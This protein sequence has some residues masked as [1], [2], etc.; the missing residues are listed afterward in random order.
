MRRAAIVVAAGT[1]TRMGADMPKALMPVAG[2]PLL[3]WSVETLS[4]C[5]LI[6]HVVVVAPSGHERPTRMALGVELANLSVTAGGASRARSV[7][8]GLERI[9]T[10]TEQ[11]VI[12]DAAR[13]LVTAEHL[14]SVLA[15][16]VD[17][18]GAII[19]A[20]AAD[21]IKRATADLTIAETLDRSELWLAQTPQAFVVA[22]LR[23]AAAQAERRGDLDAA[24]DCASLIEAIGG[25]VRVVPS[26][27]ANQKV[28]TPADLDPIASLLAARAA[29][30]R[31]ASC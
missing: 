23:A 19:A 20:P 1:G 24:T 9:P 27:S 15:G 3:A 21:T 25:T 29:A 17:A 5:Q 13:P 2:R 22:R 18:D 4:R 8:A 31:E 10:N 30:E 28:T 6:D 11:V 12:H 14:R 26:A 16:I 7:L